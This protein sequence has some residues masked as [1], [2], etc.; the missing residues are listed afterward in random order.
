MMAVFCFRRFDMNFILIYFLFE[1][2]SF[3]YDV[4]V[5]HMVD[6]QRALPLPDEVSDVYDTKRYTTFL[7]YKSD[8]RKHNNQ[9]SV[10]YTCIRFGLIFVG[11]Y[12]WIDTIGGNNEYLVVLYSS[13]LTFVLTLP[14]DYYKSY[15]F[16]F[17]IAEKYNLNKKT[18]KEFNKDFI[19]SEIPTEIIGI[20]AIFLLIGIVQFISNSNLYPM[21]PL[22][23]FMIAA[24]VAVIIVIAS[25]LI[26]LISLFI[27]RKTYTFT[28][29]EDNELKHKIYDLLEGVKKKIYHIYVYDESKKSISKN[30]FVLHFLFYREI[31]IADNFLNENAEEELLAV[32]SH[33]VGHLKH[34]K[35]VLEYLS[36]VD[37]VLLFC[38]L[39]YFIHNPVL[40]KQFVSWINASFGIQTTNY[41]LLVIAISTFLR[42]IS[43][44]IS[45]YTNYISRVNEYEADQNAVK[46][47][48]G[49]ALIKTFKTLSNDELVDVNPCKLVEISE[50]NHPGMTNRIRAIRKSL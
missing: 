40:L 38:L 41:V 6:K 23:A 2:F 5:N 44:L 50:Y 43:F 21:T 8:T 36:Y 39:T 26:T 15:L 49:E 46:E 18:K 24:I 9:F 32:L 7:K 31:S 12:K 27:F 29:M 37:I 1:V 48:Y 19:L 16:T 34:K 10:I 20:L 45:L 28:D 17:K 13:L 14:L 33:E 3:T 42:P 25:L 35:T 47:G 22:K 30:A 4:I 11:G